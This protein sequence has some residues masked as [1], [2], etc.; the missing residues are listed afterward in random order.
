MGHPSHLEKTHDVPHIVL[1]PEVDHAVC[2]VHAKEFAIV[3]GKSLLLQHI[4]QTT[5]SGNH[6]MKTLVQNMTLL[7]HGYTTDT[8]QGVER[9][10]IPGIG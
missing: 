5:R 7:A 9:G 10:V 2:F 4:D 8:E 1:E 3:K 6:D